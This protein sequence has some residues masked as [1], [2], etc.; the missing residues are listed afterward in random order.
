MPI[1]RILVTGDILRPSGDGAVSESVPRIKWFEDLLTPALAE[2]SEL[3]VRRVACEGALH[4]DALYADAGLTPSLDAWAEIYAAVLPAALTDRLVSLYQDALVISVEMPPSIALALRNAG[5]PFID[6]MVD[7]HRFLNDI[8]LAW[9]SSS[10][11]VIAAIEP[12]RLAPFEIRRRAAQIRAKSRWMGHLEVPE[13]ATLLLDQMPNDSAMIDPRRQRRVTWSDYRDELQ[14]LARSGPIVW[15]PHPY[16]QNA[17]EMTSL[18]G[19]TTCID[20]NIYRLLSHDHL[21]GVA[22]IS[23]GGVIEARAFGKQGRHFLDRYAGIDLEGWSTPL[24]VVGHW[25]SPHFWSAALAPL[26]SARTQ[27]PVV[28]PEKDFFRRSIN[29]DWGFDSMDRVVAR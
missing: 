9:R 27:V 21:A 15:R 14:A 4:L 16:G 19:P 22:A 6:C 2:V 28:A 13:G 23:S 20:A 3:P 12:F 11:E 1:S 10:P 17:D 25:L 29:C 24:P 26:V 8:P 18:M 7:P 5:I